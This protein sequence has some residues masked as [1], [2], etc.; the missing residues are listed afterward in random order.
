MICFH[1]G[2]SV[3]IILCILYR[4]LRCVVRACENLSVF[5]HIMMTKRKCIFSDGVKSK[6]PF[7]KCVNENVLPC[8]VYYQVS[9][10]F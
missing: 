1:N 7:I 2:S 6:Y 10:L 8:L 4:T 3:F 9:R 5:I